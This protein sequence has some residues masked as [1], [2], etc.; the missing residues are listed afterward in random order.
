MILPAI[1]VITRYKKQPLQQTDKKKPEMELT[2]SGWSR[3]IRPALSLLAYFL[4]YFF[5]FRDKP[6][7]IFIITGIVLLH[8]TGHF[9]SMKYFGYKDVRM[10][11]IPFLG[12]FVSG[13]PKKVSQLQRIITLFAGPVP[14]IIIGIGMLFYFRHTG[15]PFYYQ[16]SFFLIVLNVFN[17]LPVS[18][19]DGGQ[20]LE[21]LFGRRTYFLQ[22]VFLAGMGILVFGL[23]VKMGSLWLLAIVWIIV[24]ACRRLLRMVAIRRALD[25]K[26]INY[27]ISYDQLDDET[28][29]AIRK[30]VIERVNALRYIDPEKIGDDEYLVTKWV[31]KILEVPVEKDMSKASIIFSTVMWVILLV[32]PLLYLFK[33]FSIRH[34]LL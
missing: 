5:V 7:W 32:I 27:R 25:K 2:E 24:F 16:L 29:L 1:F 9:L 21:N 6:V 15:E 28:Y 18:P 26:G 20:L 8:E 13:A 23:A 30:E 17:L 12:G 34:F 10:F 31:R 14:G 33:A 19:L 22:P 3:F 11:F 4:V